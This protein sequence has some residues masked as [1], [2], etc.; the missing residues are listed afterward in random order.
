MNDLNSGKLVAAA[1]ALLF[2]WLFAR[3][4]TPVILPFFLA[5]LVALAAEP[6]VKTLQNRTKLSRNAATGIGVTIV[7]LLLGLLILVLGALLFRQLQ[8]LMDYLPDLEGTAMQGISALQNWLA[9]LVANA[10][11]GIRPMLERSVETLFSGS[12]L[13]FDRLSA[14][15]L[16]LASGI[17][18]HL[19]ESALGI[20]TWLLAS[21]MFSA[22]LPRIRQYLQSKLGPS[23]QNKWRPALTQVRHSV[24]GWLTAQLKLI[25]ITFSVLT[26]SFLLL[27]VE[28]APW[29]AGL[30]SLVDALPILGTGMVLIPW[31][32]ICF[33]QGEAVKGV[34]LAAAYLTALLLRTTLEPKLVGKQLGL[35]SLLTLAAMYA[36][37][38]LWGIFGLLLA[39]L[40]TV[41]AMQFW[42]LKKKA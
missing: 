33:L 36:G 22:K 42:A 8:N 35:D 12:A 2:I 34:G 17:V 13:F 10:P 21:F 5:A 23:W 29:I 37:Y 40:L 20:G 14:W 15:I 28:H 24:I 26:V 39:P 41:T 9:S 11:G 27:R 7:L 30:V 38:R 18:T 25:S 32:I 1:A 31:S 6:L 16:A 4:L 3:Y 19:P